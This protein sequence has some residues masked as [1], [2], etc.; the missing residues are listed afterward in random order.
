MAYLEVQ[1]TDKKV[2]EVVR[3]YSDYSSSLTGV[4]SLSSNGVRALNAKHP[5]ILEPF[6]N[7]EDEQSLQ[8]GLPRPTVVIK[9]N[10]V[11]IENGDIEILSFLDVRSLFKPE[12]KIVNL[13]KVFDLIRSGVLQTD[14]TFD[15]VMT[16]IDPDTPLT[17]LLSS[18]GRMRFRGRLWSLADLKDFT[19]RDLEFGSRERIEKRFMTLKDLVV[20]EF[21][22]ESKTVHLIK[23]GSPT[24]Y[25]A[26]F[27][28]VTPN[29]V[30]LLEKGRRVT[31]A[32]ERAYGSTQDNYSLLDPMII[33]RGHSIKRTV[34]LKS[35]RSYPTAIYNAAYAECLYRGGIEP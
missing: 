2:F 11:L 27:F 6:L 21:Y 33:P 19:V 24:P 16:P 8:R 26:R 34:V 3:L 31:L 17:E 14:P 25:I 35:P 23:P 7:K 20:K 13:S 12:V 1:I 9:D 10:K 32:A 22:P 28:Y 29:M 18:H 4:C 15:E 30:S 5:K